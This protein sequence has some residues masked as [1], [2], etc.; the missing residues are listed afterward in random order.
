MGTNSFTRIIY[1]ITFLNLFVRSAVAL[2]N[3]RVEDDKILAI[4]A[5]QAEF[6][7]LGVP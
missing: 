2:P 3:Q 7:A 1:F 6:T 5:R 4:I